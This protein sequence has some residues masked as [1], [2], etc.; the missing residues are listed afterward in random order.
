MF[1]IIGTML[2]IPVAALLLIMLLKPRFSKRIAV[3]S[4]GIVFAITLGLLIYSILSGSPNLSESYNYIASLGTTLSLRITLIPLI[5]L[6]MSSVVLL[7]TAFAGDHDSPRPKVSN[8]LIALFQLASIGLFTSANFLLFFI[9]WDVGV[10]AMFFMINVLGS[11]N[12]RQASIKFLIYEL[13]SSALLLLAILMIYFYT[14]V[15]SFDIAFITANI[16]SIPAATQA[17]IF[18]LLFAAFM[19]NMPIFPLHHWLPDAH[20]EASTQGSMLLSGILTKYGGFG[21][22]LLFAIMPVSRTW[23]GYIAMLSAF[24]VFYAV[25]LLMRQTDIKRIVAYS[26]IVEMGIVM[27]GITA[28]N[29]FGTYGAAYAMLS[30]GLVVALMFLSVGSLKHA[31]GERDIKILRGTVMNARGTTY[32]FLVGT[33]AM[34]GFPLSAGFIADIL[35]FIGAVQSFSVL[36]L[37]PLGALVLM[38][39]YLYFVINRSMLSTREQSKNTDF[40]GFRQH[41]GYAF[42]MFFIFLFGVLPFLLLN[43]VKL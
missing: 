9:F 39:A 6:F 41:L 8:T 19:I 13:L 16:A 17:A 38:G 31:F 14:P 15:H 3:A 25:F 26:T 33:L 32:A 22:I 12:R 36:G 18:A 7:A 35:I 20:T 23:A 34:I 11:A 30:H 24:S 42:L 29:S 2:A 27:F 5:L 28:L 37:I 43:L 1:P 21:M 4:T 40:V 10:I